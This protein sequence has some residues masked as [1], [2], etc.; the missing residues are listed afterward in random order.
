[1]LQP[2]VSRTVRQQRNGPQFL[3]SFQIGSRQIGMRGM[4]CFMRF[5]MTAGFELT[6][7]K[8]VALLAVV[9]IRFVKATLGA[10]TM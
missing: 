9:E 3:S 6:T 4:A 2:A 1:M 7:K 5:C 10:A 8:R